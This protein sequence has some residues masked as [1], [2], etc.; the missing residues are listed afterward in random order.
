MSYF[1]NVAW[2]NRC[3]AET[4]AAEVWRQKYGDREWDKE[5]FTTLATNSPFRVGPEN[6]NI[7]PPDMDYLVEELHRTKLVI[8]KGASYTQVHSLDEG[9][10]ETD[11]QDGEESE[12]S[13]PLATTTTVDTPVLGQGPSVPFILVPPL[14]AGVRVD[15]PR[16]MG[17]LRSLPSHSPQ[18]GFRGLERT[19]VDAHA[20][21]HDQDRVVLWVD[22]TE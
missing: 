6:L 13:N 20:N 3:K 14:N 19:H 9:N 10:G 21:N 22:P 16:T 8:E 2:H 5:V 7:D 11:A 18:I 12:A 4:E 17:S 1:T 15:V